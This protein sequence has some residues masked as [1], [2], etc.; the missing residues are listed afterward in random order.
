MA[1]VESFFKNDINAV[2]FGQLFFIMK[3]HCSILNFVYHHV[4]VW[5]PQSSINLYSLQAQRKQTGFDRP[6]DSFLFFY[7]RK[8]LKGFERNEQ[9]DFLTSWD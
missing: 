2:L 6:T 8:E 3:I 4:V 9:V 1:P 5:W 7:C